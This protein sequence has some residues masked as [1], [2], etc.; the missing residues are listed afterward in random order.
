MSEGA[1]GWGVVSNDNIV[2]RIV[3]A[4]PIS[5]QRNLD[6]LNPSIANDLQIS[7]DMNLS[8]LMNYYTRQQS[9]STFEP[10]S[11]ILVS[12]YPYGSGSD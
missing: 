11:R 12:D 1:N 10:V 7:L 5:V 2:R 6:L 4:D 3:G 9:D 8:G